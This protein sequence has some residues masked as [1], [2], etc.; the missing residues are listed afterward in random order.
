MEDREFYRPG[1]SGEEA[2]MVEEW[3]RRKREKGS[4]RGEDHNPP[5]GD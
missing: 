4:G 3:R 5:R 1:G 2:R